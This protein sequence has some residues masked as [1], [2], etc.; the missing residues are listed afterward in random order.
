MHR[1]S[2]LKTECGKEFVSIY[3]DDVIIFLESLKDHFEYSEIYLINWEKLNPRNCK[4][5]CNESAPQVFNLT[6]RVW[7]CTTVPLPTT[8]RQLKQFLRLSLLYFKI[9]HPVYVL[10]RKGFPSQLWRC[11]WD[12]KEQIT[13][14]TSFG[15]DAILSQLHSTDYTQMLMLVS[16]YQHQRQIT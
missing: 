8:L 12:L 6:E 2:G 5:V 3:L 4:F 7:C 16:W 9:A 15:L 11:I 1:Q 13:N 14:G 10:S